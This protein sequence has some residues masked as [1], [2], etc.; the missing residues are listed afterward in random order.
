MVGRY[1][2]PDYHKKWWAANKHRYNP[3]KPKTP[4]ISKRDYENNKEKVLKHQKK[5][6]QESPEWRL[7]RSAKN[8]SARR[9][10]SFEIEVED[11]TIPDVCPVF[12]IPMNQFTDYCPSIDRKDNSKGYVKGNVQVISKKSNVMKSNASNEELL[13]FAD[14]IIEELRV[15]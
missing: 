2:D 5:R 6:R 13:Q 15:K 4:E 7:W 8:S 11:I 12:K 3:R 1:K 10:L 9:G 14:W